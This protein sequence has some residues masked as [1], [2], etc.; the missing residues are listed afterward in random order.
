MFAGVLRGVGEQRVFFGWF[1]VVELWCFCGGNM[2]VGWLLSG[3]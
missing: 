2:V 1:F 3:A